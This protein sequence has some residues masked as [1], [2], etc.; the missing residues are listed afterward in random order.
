MNEGVQKA[1]KWS[2]W[3]LLL[4][5]SKVFT[6]LT[7]SEDFR[8]LTESLGWQMAGIGGNE[9]TTKQKNGL[10]SGD[11]HNPP[12]TP[13]QQLIPIPILPGLSGSDRSYSQHTGSRRRVFL[14]CARGHVC[15]RTKD[16]DE[17]EWVNQKLIF[18]FSSKER[19]FFERFVYLSNLYI[20]P[21]AQTRDPKIKSRMLQWLSRPG[22]PPLKRAWSSILTTPFLWMPTNLPNFNTWL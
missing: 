5:I 4:I 22:A 15:F 21:K 2:P 7:A 13:P 19:F 11:A 6:R 3:A 12:P 16:F 1:N 18:H 8:N 10:Q 14:V 20:E 17:K 9:D